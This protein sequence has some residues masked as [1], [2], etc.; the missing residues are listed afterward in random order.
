[1]RTSFLLDAGDVFA[2]AEP[3]YFGVISVRV[4][5][6][7]WEAWQVKLRGFRKHRYIGGHPTPSNRTRGQYRGKT[8]SNR[9]IR[10][11]YTRCSSRRRGRYSPNY[12]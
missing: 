8:S 10:R 6:N 1:V 7:V 3:Q 11:D 5:L 2:V 9:R 12:L 4:D